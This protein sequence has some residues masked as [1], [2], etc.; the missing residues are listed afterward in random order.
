MKTIVPAKGYTFD[1]LFLEPRHST[2]RSRKEP[3][4]RSTSGIKLALDIPIFSAP[5]NTVTEVSMLVTMHSMGGMGVLHRYMSIEDQ[6]LQFK[7]AQ[8]KVPHPLRAFVSIGAT[9]DYLERAQALWDAGCLN[10]CIDV[11]NGHSEYCIDAIRALR[12]KYKGQVTIMAGNVCSFEGAYKLAEAGADAIRIGIGP[13]SVCTTRIVTGHGV[14]Q[15]TAINNCSAIKADFPDVMIIGDGGI[16]S[17]GDIVKALAAG[18][19]AVMLG[20]ML[21]GTSDTPGETHRDTA[22]GSLYK[23]YHGMAS[24]SGR[25]SWFD[26][27]KT[28]FIPEGESTRVMYKGETRKILNDI[29]GGMRSGFSYSGA[30]N[31]LELQEKAKWVEVTPAGA[32]EARPH[33]KK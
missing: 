15:L 22:T 12:E 28:S 1:D 32:H 24:E 8:G 3:N 25:S 2:I 14:P 13:G 16:R 30:Y 11:A 7:Q 9:G 18:A 33:G 5:M 31:I 29:L 23:Y 27:E 26:R 21:A 20:G 6:A 10:F 17:S 19:D 4:L